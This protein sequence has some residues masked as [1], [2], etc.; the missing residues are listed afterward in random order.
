M[1]SSGSGGLIDI[2]K[3][4]LNNI[5]K[6]S[7]MM[8]QVQKTTVQIEQV[9]VFSKMSKDLEG[10]GITAAKVGKKLTSLQLMAGAVAARAMKK[11]S[12]AGKGL[13]SQASSSLKAIGKPFKALWEKN[14]AR[15]AAAAKKKADDAMAASLG[16][17]VGKNAPKVGRIKRLQNI[18]GD[19]PI[20]L[21]DD[22]KEKL[23]SVASTAGSMLLAIKDSSIEAAKAFSSAF[24]VLRSTS[25]ASEEAMSKLSQSFRTVGGQVPESLDV[26]AKTMGT[27]SRETSLTGTDL[28]RLTKVMLDASRLTGSDSA[29]A[30]ESA[31]KAMSTWG[32]AATDGEAML[33]QFFA[34]SRAGKMNMGDLMKQMAQFGE[35][36]KEMGIGFDQS[37]VLLAKWQKEGINPVEELLKKKLPNGGIAEIAGNVRNAHDA[38]MAA[39]YATEFFGDKVTG[40][41]VA[42]LRG[43]KVEFDGILGAMNQSKNGILSQTQSLQS[44]GDQWSTLQNR[45]TIAMAPLG[46][47]LLP[48]ANALVSVIEVLAEHSGII[49]ITLGTVAAFLLT[50][51]APAL[52]A[53]AV[54][55]WATVAPFAPI[56]AAAL[57]LGVVVGGVAYLIKKHMDF[58]LGC[59]NSVK[60]GFNSFLES[61]GLADGAKAT[62][63]MDTTAASEQLTSNGGP[64]PAKY[65]GM[66]YV[67]YDGM[68]A[69]LHKGERIMT[70]SENREFSQGGGGGSISITGNTFNVRQES[71]I[72][73]IA[74]ALAREIKVAGGLMA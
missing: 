71:D 30:A 38:T 9:N 40:E 13:K 42:A 1:S 45:I 18:V 41:M 64:P 56:I 55:A 17:P 16:F 46:E 11:G 49:L 21:S 53:T 29:V 31:A 36:L 58:I 43:G 61:V 59:I 54:A 8:N 4:Q 25:G 72:D 22:N 73:A 66:D 57:L 33:E 15:K 3:E 52:M 51:F 20:E 6:L 5:N 44:F 28:E 62:I 10:T 67:P 65:H 24:G 19:K 2:T 12:E 68:M 47:A 26:V 37:M 35:P 50:V 23:S 48:L 74:R 63:E 60:D 32:I 14:Q 39:A 34:V 27:L 7:K 69:R 70:A